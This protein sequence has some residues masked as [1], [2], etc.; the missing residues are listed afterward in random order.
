MKK[1]LLLVSILLGSIVL[2]FLMEGDQ[3]LYVQV[4]YGFPQLVFQILNSAMFH[5]AYFLF[6]YFS[7]MQY[8]LMKP[9]IIIRIGHKGYN[10]KISMIYGSQCLLLLVV[11][12]LS[13]YI[14]C[15]QI[16]LL[17]NLINIALL[18]GLLFIFRIRKQALDSVLILCIV[19]L[20]LA[21]F[22]IYR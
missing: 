16:F 9:T 20:F 18:L 13:D 10:K 7:I 22:L 8:E 17:D 4:K 5:I 6:L 14:V 2:G 21:K 3:T 15:K 1:Y 12:L 11:N 19:I